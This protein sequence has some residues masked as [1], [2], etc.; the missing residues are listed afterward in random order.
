MNS[1][2]AVQDTTA[3]F[4]WSFHIQYSIFMPIQVVIVHKKILEF[5]DKFLAKVLHMP[6]VRMTV[7]GLF[8]S[9]DPIVAFLILFLALQTFNYADD[10]TFQ[11]T[12]R[13]SRLVHQDEDVGWVAIFSLSRRNETEVVRES[14]T[15]RKNLFEPKNLL[16]GIETEFIAAAFRC[17]DDHLNKSVLRFV[18]R[19]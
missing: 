2:H 19:G 14:H 11:Q 6:Y 8:Y 1:L 9:D 10:A 17:L 16:V 12:A 4:V 15:C 3:S 5:L 13:K 18:H 7:V